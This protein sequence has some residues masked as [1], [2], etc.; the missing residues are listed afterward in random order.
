LPV[1]ETY[2]EKVQT[3]IGDWHDNLLAGFNFPGLHQKT[4]GLYEAVKSVT[5]N[6]YQ[7]ATTPVDIPLM[8]ID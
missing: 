7:Q 8:Q 4:R 3:A 6:F 2:L 1:N 5:A